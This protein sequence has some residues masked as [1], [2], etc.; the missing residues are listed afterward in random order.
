MPGFL[1]HLRT[2][3]DKAPDADILREMISSAAEQSMEMEVQ[4]R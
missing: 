2:L 1:M 3:V 4:W